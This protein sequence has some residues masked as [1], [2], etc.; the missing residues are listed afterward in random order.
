M[1]D[2]E[3]LQL[4]DGF[5]FKQLQ[6]AIILYRWL[7]KK[8]RSIEEV[9]EYVIKKR[10]QRFHHEKEHYDT[11]RKK[12]ARSPR[13]KDCG[14]IMTLWPVEG[15]DASIWICKGCRYSFYVDK[16]VRQVMKELMEDKENGTR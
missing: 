10:K 4:I 9:E 8:G 16:P 2:K 3:L 7:R 14:R 15:E 1:I 6:E 12:F 5:S 13:C 11:I